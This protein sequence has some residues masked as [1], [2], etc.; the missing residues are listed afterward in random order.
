MEGHN[1]GHSTLQIRTT[2]LP[3]IGTTSRFHQSI[4]QGL[5]STFYKARNLF[6]VFQPIDFSLSGSFSFKQVSWTDGQLSQRF[7]GLAFA[8]CVPSAVCCLTCCSF[9]CS[10]SENLVTG[11]R[12]DLG[13][14][15]LA[16]L[17]YQQGQNVSFSVSVCFWFWFFD[18]CS[19]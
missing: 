13:L 11:S 6:S 9:A 3:F 2:V 4:H 12:S 19:C 14:I 17:F 16:R 10:S 15:P 18:D 1:S 5:S 7:R 8:N